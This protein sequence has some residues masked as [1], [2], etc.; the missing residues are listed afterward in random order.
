M[1]SKS[2]LYQNYNSNKLK[3]LI[4]YWKNVFTWDSIPV[5]PYLLTSP[6]CFQRELVG[7]VTNVSDKTALK[8]KFRGRRTA[9]SGGH[10]CIVLAWWWRDFMNALH[11]I[12]HQL[13][14][15]IIENRDSAT[16]FRSLQSIT[17]VFAIFT[18]WRTTHANS[19]CASIVLHLEIFLIFQWFS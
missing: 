1:Q 4:K 8:W 9:A 12:L 2:K 14:A 7:L 13:C 16:H 11:A 17:I 15:E 6:W 19:T 10:A 18:C 3:F 5:Q